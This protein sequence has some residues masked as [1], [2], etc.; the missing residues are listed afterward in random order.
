MPDDIDSYLQE[1]ES[2]NSNITPGAERRI[3][4]AVEPGRRTPVAVVYLHGF[5]AT[6]EEIRPVPDR[7]AASLGANLYFA[8]LT[9][10]GQDGA[11][12]AAARADDWIADLSEALAIG[13][14]IG[15]RTILIAT[16]TG[17]TLASF[18]ATDAAAS[19]GLAGVVMISPNFGLRSVAGRI[20]DLP[21][22]R[23]WGPVVAGAERSFTPQNESHA[24]WWTTRYPTTALFPMAALVRAARDLPFDRAQVPALF[25]FSPDDRVID[26]D[27]AA[28]VARAWG[29]PV[30]VER[31]H[32]A[33]G[34]DPYSH[35]IAGD[36]LSPGQTAET[37][38]LILTW[39]RGL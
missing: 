18:A 30:Q 35:V 33:P 34:D 4:W 32:M 21:L 2:Q 9:G 25:L 29:G 36:I 23:W 5:S 15:D 17:A 6:S 19:E 22:A 26:P 1:A 31:R 7:V 11:A 20:L 24:R 14:R 3:V 38:Q 27:A 28:E 12:L 16:S 13:R 8:R 10:H 37:V 39:A